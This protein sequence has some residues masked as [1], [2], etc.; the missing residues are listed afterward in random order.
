MSYIFFSL[1]S[2]RVGIF[3]SKIH[4]NMCLLKEVQMR[5]CASMIVSFSWIVPIV[6]AVVFCLE[7]LE[8]IKMILSALVQS[9]FDAT[10]TIGILLEVTR[11]P[12][13]LSLPM[14]CIKSVRITLGSPIGIFL[15]RLFFVLDRV[16]RTVAGSSSPVKKIHNE[17]LF[18]N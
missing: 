17:F 5:Q 15:P 18:S 7:K 9:V 1:D 8:K 16:L 6:S 14:V 2:L 10:V 4:P 12:N 13:N 11:Y 3:S